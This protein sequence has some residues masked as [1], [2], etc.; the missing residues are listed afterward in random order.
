MGRGGTD[1]SRWRGLLVVAA[2]VCALVLLADVLRWM[3][4]GP[5][6]LGL[7]GSLLPVDNRLEAEAC[8]GTAVAPR[9]KSCLGPVPTLGRVAA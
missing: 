3:L 2:G 8:L 9:A 6:E 1:G 5:L 4:V 7:L